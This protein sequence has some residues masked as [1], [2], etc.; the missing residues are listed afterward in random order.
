MRHSTFFFFFHNKSFKS[1]MNS[2]LTS[3]LTLEQT[4]VKGTMPPCLV[5]TRLSCTGL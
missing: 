2:T 3:H 1:G 5:D 4:N